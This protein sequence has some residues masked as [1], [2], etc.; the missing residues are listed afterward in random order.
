MK[1]PKIVPI[2]HP[3]RKHQAFGLCM[4]CYQKQ[5]VYTKEQTATRN[6]TPAAKARKSRHYTK[7]KEN[8]PNYTTDIHR[9]NRYGL[10]PDTYK[11][12]QDKQNHKCKIC[13]SDFSGVR[14][15]IDH[16]HE[17]GKVRGLLCGLC[18]TAVGMLKESEFNFLRTVAYLK[19][20]GSLKRIFQDEEI[21]GPIR[22]M[23]L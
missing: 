5:R 10:T 19:S 9:L 13:L 3:E 22:F 14:C 1:L 21:V 7:M 12:L 20:N 18:N 17:T 2:C 4:P 8:N 15:H 16:D 23:D 6:A 11:A